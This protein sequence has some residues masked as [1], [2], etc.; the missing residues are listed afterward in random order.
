[1]IT[2]LNKPITEF[3]KKYINSK[4]SRFHTP[5]HKGN[6][7]IFSPNV[8]LFDITEI[9]D[10]DSLFSADGIILQ[11]ENIASSIYGSKLS[12]FSSAG[13]TLCI[14]TMLAL[15]AKKNAKIIAARNSHISL[16]NTISLLD[17]DPIWI[18]P[19]YIDDSG[20]SGILDINGIEDTVLKNPDAVCIYVTSPDY[21]GIIQDIKS[22]SNISK[23]YDIP[24][25]VDNAHGSILKFID[26]D[27]H[28]ISLGADMC[29]DSLHKTLPALTGAA[30]L[31]IN[32]DKFDRASVK[33]KMNYFSSTSP[34][35][36]I[37]ISIESTLEYLNNYFHKDLNKLKTNIDYLNNISKSIGISSVNNNFTITHFS[38]NC[39]S[40]GYT[41][42]EI[43]EIFRKQK[44]EPEFISNMYIVFL[45]SPFNSD[46]DISKLSNSIL[47]L[48]PKPF[49]KSKVFSMSAPE[50]VLSPNS[51]IF[52][53]SKFLPIESSLNH[54]VADT[55]VT[56]PPGIPLIMP[57]EKINNFVIEH[58]K[59]SGIKRIKVII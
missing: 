54:I 56:C 21:L 33:T 17:L 23:K 55:I 38:L 19:K 41:G 20:V 43:A 8:E 6:T 9:K 22:I 45:I 49:I 36:P 26:K 13:S 14:Q 2:N 51:S 42:F 12:V 32:S 16:I 37:L 18:Y 46:E 57:G 53:T 28:P 34:S 29:C 58:L 47:S 52:S 3:T 11:S 1:M 50:K 5:G 24:L 31:H 27:Q 44:I 39:H 48:K 30:I 35:Y 25:I 10:A 40:I 4:F 7:N 15:V 59:N